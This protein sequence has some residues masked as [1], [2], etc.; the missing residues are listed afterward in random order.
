MVCPFYVRFF[1][2]NRRHESHNLVAHTITP[3]VVC[4]VYYA[5]KRHTHT[6]ESKVFLA[7]EDRVAP[8]KPT[9]LS[10]FP[11]IFYLRRTR[12]AR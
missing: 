7:S 10:R 11:R 12:K 4:V 5:R 1:E 9:G 8:D 2:C 6:I 3:N